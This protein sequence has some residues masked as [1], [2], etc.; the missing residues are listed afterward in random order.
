[1]KQEKGLTLHQQEPMR[2]WN[3]M[4]NIQLTHVIVP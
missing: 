4:K 1:M 2:I 3:F